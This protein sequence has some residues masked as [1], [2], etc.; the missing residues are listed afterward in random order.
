[1]R[2]SRG[3]LITTTLGN[4]RQISR[5]R[6]STA[7]ADEDDVAESRQRR[8][9]VRHH[10]GLVPH[11]Q[12]RDDP[13]WEARQRARQGG[14]CE[15]LA[16]C[17][18]DRRGRRA[19]RETG[20]ADRRP[21]VVGRGVYSSTASS[22]CRSEAPRSARAKGGV[23]AARYVSNR[24]RM[25]SARIPPCRSSS[26]WCRYQTS[27]SRSS[28]GGALLERRQQE[29]PIDQR[30]V[31]VVRGRLSRQRRGGRRPTRTSARRPLRDAAHE[32]G[33]GCEQVVRGRVGR[34]R[35]LRLGR[36]ARELA[37]LAGHEAAA[38]MALENGHRRRQV[39][40]A[41]QIVF[42]EGDGVLARAGADRL[43][44]VA[45]RAQ[46]HRVAVIAHARIADAIR[47]TADTR[48]SAPSSSS[49]RS[50]SAKVC[51]RIDATARRASS[52]W[53]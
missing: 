44:H 21:L 29:R 14:P 52:S 42:V 45:H 27:G 15:R 33:A 1:M 37:Q 16:R 36:L 51:A 9:R 6:P 30:A 50:K 5:V 39:V 43:E 35:D 32:I 47:R 26:S 25:C 11:R 7:V 40:P 24:R 34:L 31:L 46:A 17:R 19:R 12:Q 8:Q 18:S 23:S 3:A 38:G 4:R 41:E 28:D 49:V 22:R 20:S 53:W 48:P 10:P 13:S 2:L